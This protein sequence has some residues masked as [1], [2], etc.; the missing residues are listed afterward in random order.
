MI[1]IE[2]GCKLII[3]D[4]LFSLNISDFGKDKYDNQTELI[5]A[6][7]ALA[8]KYGIHI[9][10]V[11]HPR[12]L[13]GYIRKV[14]ISG[15]ADLTNAVDNVWILHRN[16]LDF[17]KAYDDFYKGAEAKKSSYIRAAEKFASVDTVFE[18][19]KNRF[20]GV[21]DRT[22]GM[23]YD[24]ISRR[25]MNTLDE[26]RQYGWEDNPVQTTMRFEQNDALPFVKS[27][28]DAPF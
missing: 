18:I 14:D 23:H 3:L 6:L 7:C 11:A 16:N 17:Q 21:V 19:A 26:V 22:F 8:K 15:T 13:T 2:G 12:K 4:N 9:L 25:F 27:E 20:F 24:T 28:E 5:V 1:P 10:L